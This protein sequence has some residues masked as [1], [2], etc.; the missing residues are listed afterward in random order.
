MVPEARTTHTTTPI[1][2]PVGSLAAGVALV[3][4]LAVAGADAPGS[5]AHAAASLGREPGLPVPASAVE[6]D[7]HPDGVTRGARPPVGVGTAPEWPAQPP[8]H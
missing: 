8:D 4:A 7:V 5:A 2:Y 6:A 3:L 1:R